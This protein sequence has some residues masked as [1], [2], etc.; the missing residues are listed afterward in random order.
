MPNENLNLSLDEELVTYRRR[1]PR[2]AK[3]PFIILGSGLSNRN[4]TSMNTLKVL[5]K[6]TAGPQQLL[7]EM[8]DHRDVDTNQV[9]RSRLENKRQID[10]HLPALIEADLVRT[11][12]RGVYMINPLAVMP[13]NGTAARAM[14]NGLSRPTETETTPVT[15]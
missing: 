4:G 12:Q 6:L 8:L 11:V 2:D 14:W 9:L 15:G 7:L 10:N 13:P 1:R 3:A 5:L